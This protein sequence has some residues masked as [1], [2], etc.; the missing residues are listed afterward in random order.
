MKKLIKKVHN[1]T[2]TLEAYAD[3]YCWC[4]DCDCSAP[5][6]Y[7][8]TSTQVSAYSSISGTNASNISGQVWSERH[9]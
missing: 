5:C 6:Y 1:I 2:E 7:G 9:E 8:G 4:D 3:C